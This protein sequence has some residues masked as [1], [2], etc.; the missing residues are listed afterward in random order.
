MSKLPTTKEE[1][2]IWKAGYEAGIK[3]VER[4]KGGAIKIGEVI[5]EV[6]YKRFQTVEESD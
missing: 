2:E 5:M 4:T 3:E 6:M 1:G